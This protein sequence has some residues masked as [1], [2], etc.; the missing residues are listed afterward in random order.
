VLSR[1]ALAQVIYEAFAAP[2]GEHLTPALRQQLRICAEQA[3]DR[4]L[5]AQRPR[6]VRRT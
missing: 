5:A 1:D 2:Y 4:I 3:A 6:T